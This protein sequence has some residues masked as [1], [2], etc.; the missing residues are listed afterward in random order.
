MS[1]ADRRRELRRQRAVVDLRAG[2][3]RRAKIF[4]RKRELRDRFLDRNGLRL[5]TA[6][7]LLLPLKF[8]AFMLWWPIKIWMPDDPSDDQRKGGS[9]GNR[10]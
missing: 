3:A 2:E 7:K 8:V 10:T 1:R 6:Q 4:E 9:R 5:T